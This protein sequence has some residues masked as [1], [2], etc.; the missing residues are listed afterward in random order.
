MGKHYR[1]DTKGGALGFIRALWT[2]SRWCQFVEP[3]AGTEGEAKGVVFFRNRNGL[4]IPPVPL[5]EKD[6]RGVKKATITVQVS[7]SE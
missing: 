6:V 7:D 4:G 1:S 5:A 2:S 3:S